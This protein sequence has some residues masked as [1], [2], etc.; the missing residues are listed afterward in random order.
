V[1]TVDKLKS[2]LQNPSCLTEA[3]SA[4]QD[5]GQLGPQS[6]RDLGFSVNR[7]VA[8][9]NGQPSTIGD[10][11]LVGGEKRGGVVTRNF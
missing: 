1:L 11:C 10:D 2:L 9:D 4:P 3:A 7:S 6:H 8:V 5:V